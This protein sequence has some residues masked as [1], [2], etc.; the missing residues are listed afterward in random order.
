MTIGT[1]RDAANDAG[2]SLQYQLAANLPGMSDDDLT[3]LVAQVMSE[4]E[5]RVGTVLSK[6]LTDAQLAEFEQLVASAD[7]EDIAAWLAVNRPNYQATARI[8]RAR[9]IAEVVQAVATADPSAAIGQRRFDQTYVGSMDL[10]TDHFLSR[11]IKCAVEGDTVHV[12]FQ[13]NEA[14]PPVMIWIDLVGGDAPMFGFTGMAPS[15]LQIPL[16]SEEPLAAFAADRNRR[17]WIPKALVKTD[18]ETGQCTLIAQIAVPCGAP[19]TRAYIDAMMRR[20]ISSVFALFQDAHTK[21]L[22]AESDEGA[23]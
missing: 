4:L 7:N 5:A 14:Q 21:L 16:E 6:D 13:A 19:I 15:L 3:D 8:E 23:G 20:C 18:D 12:G 22:A 2:L 9:L 10:I 17:T 1:A 11:D